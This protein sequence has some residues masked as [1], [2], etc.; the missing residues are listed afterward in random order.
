MVLLCCGCF[1]Q[2]IKWGDHGSSNFNV[3]NY[4]FIC[5]DQGDYENL[6]SF[7]LLQK[8]SRDF[9]CARGNFAFK[10][11]IFSCLGTPK[12][13]FSLNTNHS[14]DC[15]PSDTNTLCNC[16]IILCSICRSQAQSVATL[17]A[18]SHWLLKVNVSEQ[19]TSSE[20]FQAVIVSILDVLMLLFETQVIWNLS[21]Y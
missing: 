14:V 18:Y 17:Q 1:L 4:E 2:E 20:N 15:V 21:I 10:I 12:I 6:I 5:T 3:C 7:V 13:I 11:S 19:G 9:L 8:F 16:E